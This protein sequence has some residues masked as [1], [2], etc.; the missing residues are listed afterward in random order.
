MPVLIIYV[1]SI[2]LATHDAPGLFFPL[3][4]MDGRVARNKGTTKAAKK[5]SGMVTWKI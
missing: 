1:Q 3:L 2:D 4:R 5:Y